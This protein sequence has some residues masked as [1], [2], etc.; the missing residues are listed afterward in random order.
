MT[1]TPEQLV[2]R[3]LEAYNARDVE[4]AVCEVTGGLIRTVWFF[5]PQ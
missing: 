4:V 3:Q 5:A 2:Q 1:E